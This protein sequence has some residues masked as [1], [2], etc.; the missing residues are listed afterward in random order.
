MTEVDSIANLLERTK[1]KHDKPRRFKLREKQ[2]PEQ[3]EW[4]SEPCCWSEA[5]S[6][7]YGCGCDRYSTPVGQMILTC[8]NSWH[9]EH[10]SFR[11]SEPEFSSMHSGRGCLCE[12]GP[13]V[14]RQCSSG[15]SLS[16]RI[17]FFS[18]WEKPLGEERLSGFREHSCQPG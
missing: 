4:Q 18:S 16:S 2:D 12:S 11:P 5:L 15:R 6:L 8:F 7:A 13:S 14:L 9:L 1:R 17:V 10:F 3:I